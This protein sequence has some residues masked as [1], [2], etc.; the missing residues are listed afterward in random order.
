[1]WEDAN[2]T[3][4]VFQAQASLRKLPVGSFAKKGHAAALESAVEK[5]NCHIYFYVFDLY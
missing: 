5:P 3:P 1:M 4:M 2:Y